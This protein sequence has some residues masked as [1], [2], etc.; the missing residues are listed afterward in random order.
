VAPET[1]VYGTPLFWA[2]AKKCTP[3]FIAKLV[4]YNADINH[5][6][7]PLGWQAFTIAVLDSNKSLAK[8]SIMK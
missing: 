2:I 8:V 7:G 5:K 1:E 6:I 3:A 4:E